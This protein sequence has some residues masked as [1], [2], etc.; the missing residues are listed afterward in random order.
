MRQFKEKPEEKLQR[1]WCPR[2]KVSPPLDSNN[3]KKFSPHKDVETCFLLNSDYVHMLMFRFVLCF[4]N[5]IQSNKILETIF[6]D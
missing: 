2:P 4:F 6:P 3:C 1:K 5:E